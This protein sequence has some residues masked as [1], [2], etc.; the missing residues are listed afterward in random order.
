MTSREPLIDLKGL[1]K[2]Y[3]NGEVNTLVL[4][5][6]NL[7]IHPGEFVALMG[8]SG[9]GKSTLMHI[10]GFLDRPSGGEYLFKG[11]SVAKLSNDELALM[12]RKEVGFVFQ[13]FH[14]LPKAP[15]I[16]NVMLPLVYAQ[17]KSSERRKLAEA[18]LTSVGLANRLDYLPNQ[19]S[20]G[21]KQRVA[22]ARALVNEPKVIFADEPTGNL[23][24]V[25][26]DQIMELLIELNN[27]GKTIIMVTHEPDIADHAKRIV[28]IKDGLIQQD[29]TKRH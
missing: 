13:A 3:Q 2:D 26:S 21:Q 10:L 23:D 17:T 14:L 1:V 25:S 29:I 5:G 8:P 15:V 4:K 28:R 12:R 11:Q 18:A 9:S 27:Q 16:D 20:G 22:I 6:I 7:S 19:I 24:S